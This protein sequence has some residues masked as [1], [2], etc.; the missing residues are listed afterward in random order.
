MIIEVKVTPV[1]ATFE[2][3]YR[4]VP[5]LK[6]KLTDKQMAQIAWEDHAVEGAHE[7]S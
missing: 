1:K 6:T 2:T 4:S 7:G 3:I 5:P